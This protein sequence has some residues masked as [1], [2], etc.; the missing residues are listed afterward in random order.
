MPSAYI[1][2]DLFFVLSGFLI[3]GILAREVARTGRVALGRFYLRRALRLLPGPPD[4]V[5]S[6]PVSSSGWSLAWRDRDDVASRHRHRADLHLFSRRGLRHRAGLDAAHLVARGGGVLLPACGRWRWCSWRAA[7]ARCVRG[8]APDRAGRGL[9]PARC[10]RDGLVRST[11]STTPRTHAPRS[12]SSAASWRMLL[13][14]GV[15][16]VRQPGD[17]TRRRLVRACSAV[18]P[19]EPRAAALPR[20]AAPPWSR[21]PPRCVVAGLVQ[22]SEP[23]AGRGCGST[24][25]LGW[26]GRRSYGLYL[27]N[28]PVVGIGGRHARSPAH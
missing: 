27:W 6:W 9:A 17:G 19:S 11:G 4:G 8:G 20:A 23:A 18:L 25:L 2:V 3:T 14:A 10:V 12:C 16:R 5:R 7:G 15:I 28:L 21:W 22:H 1:G 26:I 13:R 24:R